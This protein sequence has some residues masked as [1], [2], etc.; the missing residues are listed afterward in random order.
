MI[1]SLCEW[2][3]KFVVVNTIVSLLEF[4]SVMR[5]CEIVSFWGLFLCFRPH[6]LPQLSRAIP[7]ICNDTVS[8]ILPHLV[9][10][11]FIKYELDLIKSANKV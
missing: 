9:F 4:H 2:L 5:V 6:P 3:D 1:C 11:N 7:L 8:E 10:C